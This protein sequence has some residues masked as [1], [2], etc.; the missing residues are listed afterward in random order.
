MPAGTNPAADNT[1]E[2]ATS[3]LARRLEA[4][5]KAVS[6]VFKT[7]DHLSSDVAH[8]DMLT[9][10]LSDG[11]RPGW[12]LR[13]GATIV[14]ADDPGL[15]DLLGGTTLPDDRGK[16]VVPPKTGTAFPTRGT[17]VGA[18]TVAAD[19]EAHTHGSSALSVT[20]APGGTFGS[21]AHIHTMGGPTVTAL[22]DA[23]GTL[24]YATGSHVHDNGGPS[25]TASPTLG[26]LDVG[27]STD[28]AGSG[29]GHNNIQPT[30]VCGSAW[31][32]R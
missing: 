11:G 3:D 7:G 30:R 25:A 15:Y 12:W 21:S 1:V 9:T 20:G 23:G 28:S 13:N 10:T 4:L 18:E 32:K 29:G 6:G 24:S 27:G 5:E 8:P 26:S 22:L 17:V 31:I 16:V 14:Q 19:L 2:Y